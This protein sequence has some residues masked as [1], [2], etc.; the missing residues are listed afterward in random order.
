MDPVNLFQLASQKAQWLSVRQ[1]AVANNIANANTPGYAAVDVEPFE[2]IL[3]RTSVN[4]KATD[5]KHFGAQ[6]TEAGYKLVEVDAPAFSKD[7]SPV[8]IEKELER[9]GEV[10]REFELSTAIVKSFHRMLMM[11]AKT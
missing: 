2:Q 9:S 11:A 7:G 3:G 1:T 8:R 4:I 6:P 10:R 5:P